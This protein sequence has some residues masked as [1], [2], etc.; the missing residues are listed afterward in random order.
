M[1]RKLILEQ[2]SSPDWKKVNP[3]KVNELT[4]AGCNVQKDSDGKSWCKVGS[5]TQCA[6]PPPPPPPTTTTT[7]TSPNT[8]TTTTS[9]NT[10]T[11]TTSNSSSVSDDVEDAFDALKKWF[12]GKISGGIDKLFKKDKIKELARD[13]YTV[14]FVDED[15]A[16]KAK[17]NGEISDYKCLTNDDNKKICLGKRNGD[18]SGPAVADPKWAEVLSGG[19]YNTN[20]NTYIE[21]YF[22]SGKSSGIYEYY[23][24]GTVSHTPYV[25]DF[26]TGEFVKSRAPKKWYTW[27]KTSG[28]INMKL[29]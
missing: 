16:K 19:R 29:D 5:C 23:P 15:S 12:G 25:E 10:T 27:D 28:K 13:G 3:S 24:N 17:E 21:E 4:T 9:P 11:T 20:T 14:P 2:Y 1:K 22:K 18:T 7:T 6:A 8:T 26:E